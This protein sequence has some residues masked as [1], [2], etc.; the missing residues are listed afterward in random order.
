MVGSLTRKAFHR[1]L[2]EI[3][4]KVVQL[5]AM[6][7]EAIAAATDTL[8]TSDR[9]TARQIHDRDALID[10]LYTDV[11]ALAERNVLLQAPVAQEGRFLLGVLRIVPELERSADLAEHIAR[12][13]AQRL[14][15]QLTP[16][17]RGRVE[18]MGRINVRLWHAAADAYAERSPIAS[19]ALEHQDDELDELAEE[20]IA[21]LG[22]GTVPLPAALEMALVGRFYERLGDHAINISKRIRYVAVGGGP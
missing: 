21:D 22:E 1:E 16:T 19:D 14:G 2:E 7:T 17:M 3:D 8:L 18:R 12:R 20:V 5:F 15:D 6:V 9:E 11:E 4:G 13:A 10:G